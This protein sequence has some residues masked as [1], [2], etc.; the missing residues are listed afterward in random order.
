MGGAALAAARRVRGA[1]EGARSRRGAHLRCD[2]GALRLPRLDAVGEAGG[3]IGAREDADEHA[4]GVGVRQ[5][6][7]VDVGAA[8]GGGDL[9]VR[10]GG[11]DPQP[12]RRV[13]D[14]GVRAPREEDAEDE[15]VVGAA[16]R[17]AA[18]VRP[19]RRLR[20]DAR[21]RAELHHLRRRLVVGLLVLELGRRDEPLRVEDRVEDRRRVA[22]AEHV[23]DRHRH[24]DRQHV[25]EPARQLEHEDRR[26]DRPRHAGGHRRGAEHRVAAGQHGVGEADVEVAHQLADDAADAGADRERG[27]EDAAGE[28]QRDAD[29]EEREARRH[30]EEQ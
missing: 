18:Q 7:V 22:L 4:V 1:S 28:R 25:L 13:G 8:E 19:E 23:R 24:Q 2:G 26:R 3:D 12:Q 6:L 11:R 20:V 15:V 17:V 10:G 30:I 27:R 14:V 9:R 16:R 29:D 5:E 21:F